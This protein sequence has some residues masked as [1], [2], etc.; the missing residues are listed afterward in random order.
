MKNQTDQRIEQQR[1][2]G[3]QEERIRNLEKQLD[4]YRRNEQSH[5][6]NDMIS[7]DSSYES[8]DLRGSNYW[9]PRYKN[10]I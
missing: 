2:I 7:N 8:E 3:E 5:F 9:S 1:K 10:I 4:L 6:E